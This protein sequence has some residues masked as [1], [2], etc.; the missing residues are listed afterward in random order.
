MAQLIITSGPSSSG[1]STWAAKRGEAHG[2][3]RV[4]DF[5]QAAYHLSQGLNVVLDSVRLTGHDVE[6][7]T[8]KFEPDYGTDRR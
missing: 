7:K 8:F 3:K 5:D 4:S 2:W 6:V 1:K